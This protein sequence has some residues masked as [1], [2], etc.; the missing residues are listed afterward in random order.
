M[1]DGGEPLDLQYRERTLK[2]RSLVLLC[3]VSGSM[4]R[5]SRMLLLLVQSLAGA[6]I[7]S[8]HFFLPRA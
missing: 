1:R 3:D 7:A 2:R 6:L 5:Y 4:D 8:R